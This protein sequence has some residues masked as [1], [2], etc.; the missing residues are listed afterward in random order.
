[1]F[2]NFC[3][4]CRD[5][6]LCLSTGSDE[7]YAGG[8]EGAFGRGI[9]HGGR[10]ETAEK[11][12]A[13]ILLLLGAVNQHA[14]ANDGAL[15]LF[16]R[17]HYFHDRAASSQDIVHNQDALTGMDGE[18]APENSCLTFFLGEHSLYAHLPGDFEGEDN[19]ARGR[20]GDHLDIVFLEVLGDELA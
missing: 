8:A 2:L 11:R 9:N 18:A 3:R 6:G 7:R 13:K 14:D 17:L 4:C 20:A 10:A 16:N 15:K 5:T 1:M 12:H 19:A